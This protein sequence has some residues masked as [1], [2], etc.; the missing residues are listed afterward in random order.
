MILDEK[1]II[2]KNYKNFNEY[3]ED[4]YYDA[5][6]RRLGSYIVAHKDSFE[7]E[8]F[9]KISWI[10]QDD[11]TYKV[12]GTTFKDLGDNNIEIRTTIEA[13][14]PFQGYTKYGPDSDGD[15]KLYNV[16]LTAH[17]DGG[18]QNEKIINIT[19]YSKAAF[20]KDKT[21]SQ[22]WL[23]YLYEEKMDE[24][25]EDFLRRNYPKALLQPMPIDP[26]EVVKAMNMKMYYAPLG[27][28]VFGKTYFEEETV[29]VFENNDIV[30]RNEVEILATPG[31]MLIN[32]DVFFMR[33]IGTAYNTIIHE[34][35]HWD[36]HK[37][38]F[39]LIRL[40]M[41]GANHISC[42]MVEGEYKGISGNDNTL[43][44]MEWQANQLA[45]RI[46][47]PEKTVRKI[48]SK[49]LQD[50][51]TAHPHRRYAETLQ[52]VVGQVAN[53]F[54]V[55]LL[56]AK[57]RLF[58]LGYE[59]VEGTF[60]YCEGKGLPPYAFRKGILDKFHSF[61]V[62]EQNLTISLITNPKLME[63]FAKEA[64]VYANCMLCINDPK[65]VMLNELNQ[66]IP[67]EYALEHVD[68]CCFIFK[69]KYSASEKYPDTFYR[70][71]F[72]CR[73]IDAE[74]LVP[75]EYDSN[76]KINQSKED[77]QAEIDTIMDMINEELIDVHKDM[78]GG[79]AGAL[80][81]FMT[82]KGVS[83]YQMQERT[84]ISTVSISSYR[85]TYDP[86][87]EKGTV[88]ALIK[89]L[90]LLPHEAIYLLDAAD[91]KLTNMTPSNI[92]V[93]LLITNHMDDTWEQ[94]VEKLIMSGIARDWIP[95]K[96]AVVKE[97][98]ERNKE[99]NE[100]SL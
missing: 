26:F 93:R 51:Y 60:V 67:T 2:T 62:D 17:L 52:E 43:E 46:L 11:I 5:F 94:W 57:L 15:S 20:D 96:N 13:Q 12:C 27:D 71:C 34:C 83:E 41:G 68:E 16:F 59:E 19:E 58:E 48:Y 14:V 95:A 33:N 61:V 36:R 10:E 53:Y 98:K 69:R 28:K 45:P 21:M 23:S 50:E 9:Y 72:L 65:Y 99:E 77:M 40:L 30:R 82:T 80:D 44:W 18:L 4:N 91:I 47:M 100:K 35:V 64:I 32:P 75:V 54:S 81:Y 31:T 49:L 87:M 66:Y 85:N 29:T 25:A 79:F 84:G 92:F 97:V 74:E 89:G 86:T 3:V 70:R 55:S 56:A 6:A 37:R 38:A 78:K 88:L 24:Y 8:Q 42:E 7:N 63:L 1:V 73:E 90:C 22:S 76:H 39:E